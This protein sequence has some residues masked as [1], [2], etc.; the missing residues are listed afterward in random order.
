MGDIAVSE[1][2]LRRELERQAGRK[3]SLTITDNHRSMISIRR[4]HRTVKV[5]L[6]HMFLDAGDH[7]LDAL[8]RYVETGE[9]GLDRIRE[10]IQENAHRV[11]Y[12]PR[13]VTVR[14]RG[15]HVD[16]EEVLEEVTQRH[17]PHENPPHITWGRTTPGKN[18]RSIQF[19]SYDRGKNLI[20]INP[21]LDV[22]WVPRYFLRYLIFHEILHREI[23]PRPGN[24]HT[25]E[26]MDRLRK[27]PDYERA[28]SW[29]ENN[30]HRF[31]ENAAQPD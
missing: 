19:G 1:Q 2:Q 22:P 25:G 9:D 24:V 31:V 4:R 13:R 16:L 23:P 12:R 20:R 29:Q 14:P 7:V 6:H 3:L 10:Y 27:F 15:E 30:L 8:G 18:Q 5:R 11:N 21:K 26:F 28:V 17:F